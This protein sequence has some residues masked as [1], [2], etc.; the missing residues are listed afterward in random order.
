MLPPPPRHCPH[1][2]IVVRPPSAALG[3]LTCMRAVREPGARWLKKFSGCVWAGSLYVV[4]P[5]SSKRTRR[6]ASAAARRL[7]MTHAAVPPVHSQT[8]TRLA[9]GRQVGR[10]GG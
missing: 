1:G 10:V 4:G 3:W 7:A 5:A 2:T 9:E 6:F 8:F